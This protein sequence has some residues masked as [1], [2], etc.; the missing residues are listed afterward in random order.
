MAGV[1]LFVGQAF[2]QLL[3]LLFISDTVEYGEVKLG[4]RNDSITLSIQPLINKIGGAI[5]AGIVSQVLV[6]SGVNSATSAADI[7]PEGATFFKLAMLIIPLILIV[8]GYFVYR[9][10]YTINEESYLELLEEI[11]RRQHETN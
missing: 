2:I 6:I 3:M 10:K 4:K 1:L 8:I 7:T 11:S 5:A 9:A